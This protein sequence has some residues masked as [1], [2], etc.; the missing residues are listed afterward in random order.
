VTPG[1]KGSRYSGE[2]NLWTFFKYLL[3]QA[4]LVP[5]KGLSLKSPC[6][7]WTLKN[8]SYTP[9]SHSDSSR[10]VGAPGEVPA[11]ADDQQLVLAGE[12]GVHQSVLSNVRC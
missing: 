9:P 10:E 3:A 1:R 6:R 5:N 8:S 11:G 7:H 12:P 2:T 4:Q